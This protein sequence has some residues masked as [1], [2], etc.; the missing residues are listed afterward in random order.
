VSKLNKILKSYPRL[1][2]YLFVIIL[3]NI[4]L[5]F[6]PLFNVYGFEFA[7]AN[8]IL[9]VFL[10]GIYTIKTFR[11]AK[12]SS[13]KISLF[14]YYKFPF[15]LFLIFPIIIS[16]SHSILTIFCSLKYGTLFYLVI[17]FPSII[18]GSA[19]GIFSVFICK[20]FRVLFFILITIAILLIP[21]FEF[22]FNP[23]VYFFNPIFGYFP[24]TIYDEGIKISGKLVAYRL[25]NIIYFSA[26]SITCYYS[27]KKRL[28]IPKN[29]LATLI[30]FTAAVFIYLSPVLGYSTTNTSLRNTLSKKIE[31]PHFTIYVN[32][33]YDD[34]FAKLISLEHEFYFSQLS[35]FFNKEPENKI[36]SYVFASSEQKGNL[37]GS[38]NADV[39]K[40]WLGQIYV[41]IE[42]Y[43][44]TL[45]HE[46]AHIFSANFG[47]G[48]FKVADNYN[49]ALIEGVAVAA[50]PV[51]DNNTIDYMAALAYENGYQVNLA[52][53][54]KGFNFFNKVSSISY[55]YSGSF[56]K[57]LIKNFGIEKF[58]KFYSDMDFTRYYKIKIDSVIQKYIEYIK[59]FDLK[60]RKAK[61]D[62]YFGRQT[63][64]QKICPRYIAD[65]L[66]NGWDAYS[67]N[68]YDE[69]T[70]IFKEILNTA[71]VYSAVI[72]LS[73]SL[74]EKNN[75]GAAIDTLRNSLRKFPNTAY[76]YNIQFRLADYYAISGKINIADSLYKDLVVENPNRN[77]SNLAK[78]RIDLIKNNQSLVD[79]ITGTESQ[80][81]GI[82]KVINNNGYVYSSIP[83][84]INLAE[85]T[86]VDYNS[87]ITGFENFTVSDLESSFA[88]FNLS[89][90][91]MK[92]LDFKNARKMASL[93]LRYKE[94]RNFYVIAKN[95]FVKANWFYYNADKI[96]STLIITNLN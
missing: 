9:L 31:T 13:L 35:E 83:F 16:I 88:V 69:S 19:L 64:F 39:A 68:D 40:P 90:F 80:K 21:F 78:F 85:L 41:S 36:N 74:K 15:F 89:Q 25:I 4:L 96:F 60:Y 38:A 84:Y 53:I 18:I 30:L 93:A 61:A 76:Y 66:E 59:T 43:K 57:Y 91:M 28:Q 14:N 92:K 1:L 20:R 27:L 11:Y 87:F 34:N 49:P 77:L 45:K 95:N 52:Y 65:R 50:D 12:K 5:L 2:I 79:Y 75:L 33:D 55:I 48:I 10:S 51:F 24:G 32:P 63:I 62:Y 44:Q 7:F 6:L 54:F 17:T 22:Y 71:P 70:I 67:S 72:G 58:K 47:T 56:T 46:I 82:I 8:S 26:I 42:S 81:L 3:F 86:K 94:D 23:Q 29:V 37:F 73:S